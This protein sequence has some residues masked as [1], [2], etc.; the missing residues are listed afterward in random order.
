MPPLGAIKGN[1]ATLHL[2]SNCLI[3][4]A[5]YYFCGFTRLRSIR[6]DRN[7]LLAVPNMTPLKASLTILDLSGNRIPSFEPFMTNTTFPKLRNLGVSS[8]AITYLRRDIISCW[9]KLMTLHLRNNLL[10]NLEDL[11]GVIRVSSPTLT[12]LYSIHHKIYSV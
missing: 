1:L 9:P 11:S 3:E 7:K 10:K 8:N 6:L 5:R 2:S 12:V 4:I